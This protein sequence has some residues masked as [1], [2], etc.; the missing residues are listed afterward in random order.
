MAAWGELRQLEALLASLRATIAAGP[1][2][3]PLASVLRAPT[4]LAT[5]TEVLP[6]VTNKQAHPEINKRHPRGPLLH[7]TQVRARTAFTGTCCMSNRL[8]GSETCLQVV[9]AL[10]PGQAPAMV[11]FVAEGLPL[12]LDG[13]ANSSVLGEVQLLQHT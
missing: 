5:L 7:F 13:D 11:R 12:L 8:R 6:A 9:R 1:A 2:Q 10:P 3:P 4:F